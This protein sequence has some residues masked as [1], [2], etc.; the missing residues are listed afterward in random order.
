LHLLELWFNTRSLWLSINRSVCK[1]CGL[2]TRDWWFGE[3]AWLRFDVA[4]GVV[5]DVFVDAVCVCFRCS[6][7]GRGNKVGVSNT[8]GYS[9]SGVKTSARRHQ[10]RRLPRIK[11]PQCPEQITQASLE[12]GHGIHGAVRHRSVGI[13]YH[14]EWLVRPLTMLL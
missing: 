11:T 12:K 7:F 3:D 4:A 8:P 2:H 9:T 5:I 10:I 13:I 14:G 6:R 1:S